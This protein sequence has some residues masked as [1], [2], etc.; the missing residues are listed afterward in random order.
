MNLKILYVIRDR[1]I[2]WIHK[3]S[4]LSDTKFHQKYLERELV[5]KILI[6][7]GHLLFFIFDIHTYTHNEHLELLFVNNRGNKKLMA[8]TDVII[9]LN[10]SRFFIFFYSLLN[11]FER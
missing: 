11:F 9:L 8:T 1:I 2:D 3:I 7:N 5:I 6:N 4:L 10:I